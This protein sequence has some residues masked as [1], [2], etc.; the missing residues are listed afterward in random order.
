MATGDEFIKHKLGRFAAPGA[1]DNKEI[2]SIISTADTQTGFIG[3]AIAK[4]LETS[5]FSFRELKRTPT[6]VYLVLPA[7]FLGT[8]GKWF[9]LLIA[10][11]LNAL[12]RE[13]RGVP[14]LMVLDEFGQLGNLAAISNA[15]CMSA[16]MGLQL[17]PILQNLTQLKDHYGAGWET[18]L[19]AADVQQF[20]AP[21]DNFTAEYLSKLCGMKTVVLHNT[22]TG[23]SESA[24]GGNNSTNSSYSETQR[25]LFE[26]YETKRLGH[27]ESLIIGHGVNNVIR[28]KRGAYY[29]ARRYPE[30]VGR[31]DTDPYHDRAASVAE[32]EVAV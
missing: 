13:E 18:F 4:N 31:Y 29:D 11:A 7:R 30:F 27:D 15:L 6:T 17:W 23:T 10:S 3:S 28:A 32:T 22:S 21:H 26:P 25:P 20:F 16:G 24:S 14:V 19:A 12:L 8:G 5:D 1:W 2:Q 9:R